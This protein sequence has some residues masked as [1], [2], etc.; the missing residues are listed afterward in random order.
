MR[1]SP[2]PRRRG[3]A[4]T[5]IELIVVITI[6]GIISVFVVPAASTIIMGTDLNRSAQVLS[7][8]LSIARQIATTKNHA[9]EVRF[10]QF[11]DPEQPGEKVED[12]NTWQFRAIQLME[13][14]DNGNYAQVGKFERLQGNVVMDPSTYSSVLDQSGNAQ[15]AQQPLK[16]IRAETQDRKDYPPLPRVKTENQ[17]KYHYVAF[18]FLS[19][20]STNLNPNGNWYVTLYQGVDKNKLSADAQ[21]TKPPSFNYFTA[22]IDPANGSVRGFR[23]TA[24]S[25]A[26]GGT[27]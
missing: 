23:P 24:G 2:L 4:F 12:S 6:I 15:P 10:I 13:V 25:K 14:F 7:A 16:L 27:Q 9:V 1:H 22:Q 20:G 11:A 18:R 5:L 3:S 21:S 17:F 26:T 19:D 8:Q